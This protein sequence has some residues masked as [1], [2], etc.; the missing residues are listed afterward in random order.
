MPDDEPLEARI[1]KAMH[2]LL[3]W[4]ALSAQG[5]AAVA[6][7]FELSPAQG[8]RAAELATSILQGAGAWAWDPA[9]I[10]WAGNE[11]GISWRGQYRQIDRLVLRRDGQW[12]VLD[13][14][15]AAAPQAQAELRAQL[16]DYRAAVQ[17]LYPDHVVRAAFLTPQGVVLEL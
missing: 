2:R 11:V 5:T 9:V 8:A 15:T 3:E 4:G 13:Y 14:K 16:T 12:W 7:E 17:A 10:E 6:R 1:G